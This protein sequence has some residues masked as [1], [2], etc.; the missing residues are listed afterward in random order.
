MAISETVLRDKL[1]ENSSLLDPVLQKAVEEP[2]FQK[3]CAVGSD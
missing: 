3:L 2:H 1:V